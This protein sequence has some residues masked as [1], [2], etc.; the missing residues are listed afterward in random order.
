MSDRSLRR[1]GLVCLVS[2]AFNVFA[3]GVLASNYMRSTQP[4][5][6]FPAPPPGARGGSFT[7]SLVPPEPVGLPPKLMQMLTPEQRHRIA[8]IRQQHAERI[9]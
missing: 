1:I 9:A 5:L 6:P 8:Q 3:L 2:L 7:P 4:M